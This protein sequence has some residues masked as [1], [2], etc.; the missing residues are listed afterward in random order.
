[1]GA[2]AHLLSLT[3][4]NAGTLKYSDGWPAGRQPISGDQMC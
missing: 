1:M 3:I 4:A 2:T